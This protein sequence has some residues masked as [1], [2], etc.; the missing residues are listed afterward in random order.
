MIPRMGSLS[1]ICISD[2]Q[3]CCGCTACEAVCPVHCISMRR[4]SEGFSYPVTKKTECI[5]CG[6]CERVCPGLNRYAPRDK[7]PT[8]AYIVRNKDRDV[9]MRSTAG[10]FSFALCNYIIS[11]GGVMYGVAL[12][13]KLNVKHIRTENKEECLRFSG[14]KYVQSS[15]SGIFQNVKKELDEGRLVGFSGTPCQIQGLSNYLGRNDPNLILLDFV[16]HGVASETVWHSYLKFEEKRRKRP[17][18]DAHFRSKKYGYQNSTMMLST[19]AEQYFGSPRTNLYLKMYYS[20]IALRPSCYCCTAK[21]IQRVSDFTVFDSWNTEKLIG[22]DDNKG[23][24][25]LVIQ[26]EKGE[27]LFSELRTDLEV[28]P[29]SLAALLPVGGGHMTNSAYLNPNRDRFY[30]LLQEQGFETAC[31][32]YLSIQPTDYVIEK[33]KMT[34][35]HSPQFRRLALMK[36]KVSRKRHTS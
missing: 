33:L 32:Q 24:T 1:M 10:G 35:T 27:R 3:Q 18:R 20:N 8:E 29:V 9:L 16:C 5:H 25:S 23:Y 28:W 15:L 26:T 34:L 22:R 12:D 13:E 4:D 31:N 2:R 14:S 30:Q 19:G 36:R 17:I 6:M 21:T 7:K 11:H